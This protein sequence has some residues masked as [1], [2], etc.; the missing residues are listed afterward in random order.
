MTDDI[1]LKNHHV[2]VK[3]RESLDVTG[4]KKIESL[5]AKEFI[6]ETVL[7]YM[8]IEGDNLEMINLNTNSGELNIKG[9][10]NTIKYHEKLGTTDAKK[11]SFF[12]KLF[13]WLSL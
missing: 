10:V 1:D 12:T 7:G 2:M 13:K 6:L 4:I 5:N 11:E 9:Y 8:T 3:N